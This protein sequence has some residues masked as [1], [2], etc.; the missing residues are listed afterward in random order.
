MAMFINKIKENIIEDRSN[1]SDP[2]RSSMLAVAEV[3]TPF[4]QRK[5][6]SFSSQKQKK[7]RN[8]SEDEINKQDEEDNESIGNKLDVDLDEGNGKRLDIV[9]EERSDYDS[10][11]FDEESKNRSRLNNLSKSSAK[12]KDRGTKNNSDDLNDSLKMSQWKR[13][14][15]FINF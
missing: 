7:S 12:R 4:G 1:Q 10:R 5:K 11:F 14:K 2:S 9:N 13:G 8:S 6:S 3:I 15:K